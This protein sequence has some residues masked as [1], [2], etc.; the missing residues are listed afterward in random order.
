MNERKTEGFMQRMRGKV[1]SAWGDITDD[2]YD[3]FGGNVDQLVG[4]V[5][6]KTGEAE[7]SIRERLR[8]MDEEEEEPAKTERM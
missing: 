6:Q 5:K 2:E 8:K 3:K 1:K 4:W 7:D